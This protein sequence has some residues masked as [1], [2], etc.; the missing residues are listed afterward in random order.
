[1]PAILIPVGTKKYRLT[2][3]GR[4]S[5]DKYGK[6]KFLCKCDCGNET[7]I[8]GNEFRTG[9]KKSCGCLKKEGGSKEILEKMSRANQLAPGETSWKKL[10]YTHISNSKNSKSDRKHNELTIEDYKSICSQ[11]C[12]YCGA[13]PRSYNPY[14]L[15]SDLKTPRK[16]GGKISEDTIGRAWIKAHGIDRK[17]NGKEYTINN[18]VSCCWDCNREKGAMNSEEYIT[19]RK[20]RFIDYLLNEYRNNQEDRIIIDKLILEIKQGDK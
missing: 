14:I 18:S 1:M 17:D 20:R 9:K 2:V 7:T 11:C 16:Y 6:A 15:M 10:F 5:P 8:L 3:I 12:Y 4:L 13:E 19:Y